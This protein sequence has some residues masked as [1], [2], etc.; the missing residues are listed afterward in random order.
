M[1]LWR[2]FHEKGEREDKGKQEKEEKT[3]ILKKVDFKHA[4]KEALI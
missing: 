2:D 1:K 4:S 3:N